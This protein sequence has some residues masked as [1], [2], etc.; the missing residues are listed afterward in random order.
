M[1][2]ELELKSWYLELSTRQ[3]NLF[4]SIQSNPSVP[5][6]DII[7][8]IIKA[9]GD[10]IEIYSREYT[11]PKF[12]KIYSEYLADEYEIL[13][14]GAPKAARKLLQHIDDEDPRVSLS[15]SKSLLQLKMKSPS[16]HVHFHLTGF[17][18]SV[19]K[20]FLEVRNEEKQNE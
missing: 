7:T 12:K 15:A 17:P 16:Q 1:S 11:D 14:E 13:R 3:R 19:E 6:Y 20:R 9:T 5:I 10:E 2:D 8:K 4:K 18:S